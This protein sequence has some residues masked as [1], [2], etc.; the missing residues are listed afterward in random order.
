MEK[1]ESQRKQGDSS[2]ANIL[3]TTTMSDQGKTRNITDNNKENIPRDKDKKVD[4]T[5][6]TVA[7]DDNNL[8]LS[9][10][11]PVVSHKKNRKE[12]RPIDEKKPTD[13]HR[14]KSNRNKERSKPKQRNSDGK[15]T[16]P[17]ANNDSSQSNN[18]ADEEVK[19]VKFVEAPLP[20]SNPWVKPSQSSSDKSKESNRKVVI[21]APKPAEKLPPKQKQ[22][23]SLSFTLRN[24]T[25]QIML[26]LGK[27]NT[28]SCRGE[29]KTIGMA[30]TW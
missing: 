4:E 18:S 20:Q 8:D 9:G 23:V 17:S 22:T 2:L 26:F 11:V 7:T 14:S 19:K 12:E 25:T 13:N 30:F 1:S 6:S 27:N 28:S 3:T 10:F 15:S 29:W 16:K 21:D 5:S 24:A